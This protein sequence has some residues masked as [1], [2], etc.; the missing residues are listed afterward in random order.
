MNC[1]GDYLQRVPGERT[2]LLQ[3][4]VT[5]QYGDLRIG[6]R[7]DSGGDCIRH[8]L[9]YVSNV[10]HAVR[11]LALL[12]GRAR[13][14]CLISRDV[15][16]SVVSALA[17]LGNCEAILSDAHG[18]P[19]DLLGGMAHFR[20]PQDFD[21]LADACGRQADCETTWVVATSGTTASPKLV[22]HTL[23]SLTRT[24]KLSIERGNGVRW[25]L[26]YDFARFAGLQVLLQS[27]LSGSTLISPSP[28]APLEQQLG[29]LVE[30]GCTHL[31]A[32]PT[33]WRKLLMLSGVER[34]PLKQA[35]LGGEI[36]DQRVLSTLQKT[37]PEARV[38]HIYASTEAG[39]GFSVSDGLAGF[40]AAFVQS[41]PGGVEIQVR[42]G[43][44]FVRNCGVRGKYIGSD[45][46]FAD[47]EG[48]VDTGDAVLQSGDRYL[49]LGRENGV[50]NVGGS[51]VHPEE[52]ERTLLE[53]P[54]VWQARVFP[55]KS[56]ITGALV[57]AEVVPACG[58]EFQ[59]EALRDVLLRHCRERLARYAVPAELRIV[60]DLPQS[61]TG[62]L[63]R[64]N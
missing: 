54:Y 55:R 50:I 36:A 13:S 1:L 24:S 35:T 63:V 56:P 17:R 64:S 32:T 15:R 38:T 61:E 18:L 2:A 33:L 28:G 5:T 47:S 31:S 34:L 6:K 27:L 23:S 16:P 48:F 21:G 41:A 8:V 10:C 39:V 60:G 49:F 62:K 19:D 9:M 58:V 45:D 59:P 3:H 51:K 14:I 53:S 11:S 22:G 12:D 26:L 46:R 42:Q 7:S 57:A 29:E 44:L 40:P 37:F 52:V 20:L 43:R 25:G 4:C 30:G